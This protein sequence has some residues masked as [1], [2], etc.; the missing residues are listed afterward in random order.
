MILFMQTRLNK[1]INTYLNEIFRVKNH[2][3]IK[4][5]IKTA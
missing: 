5:R 1:E 4:K 3:H 2:E